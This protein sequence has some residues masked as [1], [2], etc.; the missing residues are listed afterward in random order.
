M[1][2]PFAIVSKQ[3][4][5]SRLLQHCL[6]WH[7]KITCEFEILLPALRRRD[8]KKAEQVNEIVRSKALERWGFSIKY[9]Q[10]GLW[11]QKSNF[12]FI[13][14]LR[15]DTLAQAVSQ[16]EASEKSKKLSRNFNPT[17]VK[18][19]MS[20]YR[21]EVALFRNILKEFQVFEVSYEQLTQGGK[22]VAH[23]STSVSYALCEFIGVEKLRLETSWRKENPPLDKHVK[24]Y[25]L[26]RNIPNRFLQVISF[27]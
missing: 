16:I 13:H 9:D 11:K 6:D 18:R 12:K 20:R 17:T 4:T 19:Q 22:D 7:P 24:N 1:N 15:N 5:G 25:D 26:L 27:N 23:L 2:L 21:K 10:W 8:P 14:L 3:R